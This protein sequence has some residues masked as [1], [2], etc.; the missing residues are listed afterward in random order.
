[1]QHMSSQL[2]SNEMI[3]IYFVLTN[4][5]ASRNPIGGM[6]GYLA[7]GYKSN[8]PFN[9]TFIKSTFLLSTQD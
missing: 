8:T 1:M 5:C 6:W 3:V 7:G 4:P 9:Q 2:L